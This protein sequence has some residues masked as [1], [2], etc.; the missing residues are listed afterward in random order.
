VKKLLLI[1][2][3]YR[4]TGGEDIAVQNELSILKKYFI[5]ETVVFSNQVSNY[6]GKILLFF[7][8]K[9][10]S[11]ENKLRDVVTEFKPD[12]AYV[13]NTWFNASLSVFDILKEENIKTI[14]KLHNFRYF[15]T[16]TFFHKRHIKDNEV[17]FACG[18][19]KNKLR[20]FNKYYRNSYLKSLMVIFYGK[21]YFKVLQGN[22]LKLLVLTQFHKNFLQN[23]GVNKEK[24]TVLPNLI[25]L[26]LESVYSS[27]SNYI[28]YAGRISEEKG[29]DELIRAFLDANLSNLTLK[30][31]GNGPSINDLKKK[32]IGKP[33][34]FINEI[35]NADVLDI[36]SKSKGVVTATKL[37]EGQPTLLC[38]ASTLGVPSFFPESGGIAEFFPK[39]YD[40]SYKQFDYVDLQNKLKILN[41]LETLTNQ[42]KKNKEFISSYL[43]EQ[44]LVEKFKKVIDE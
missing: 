1:H 21:R 36:I 34:D 37:Y 19:K 40:L 35:S 26:N 31:I 2:N 16:R 41:N 43:D 17:C 13:H 7:S 15:C 27:E 29:I 28:V 3:N 24:I 30:I 23:L 14:L 32:Y 44:I 42:G 22:D 5:V 6:F 10:K 12:V 9:S 20:F 39:D 11:S 18:Q 8:S 25:N 4:E 38:E 33:V